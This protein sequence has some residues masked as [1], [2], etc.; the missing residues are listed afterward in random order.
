MIFCVLGLIFSEPLGFFFLGAIVT[1][2]H[3]GV[4]FPWAICSYTFHTL[5]SHFHTSNVEG[6]APG[7]R[8]YRLFFLHEDFFPVYVFSVLVATENVPEYAKFI[9][10][11][12]LHTQLDVQPH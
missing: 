6:V 8:A 11:T 5:F 4:M 1:I 7:H 2:S 3:P 10:G 9:S 12:D